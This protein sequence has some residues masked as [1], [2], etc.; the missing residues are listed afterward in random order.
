MRL[1]IDRVSVAYNGTRVVHGVSVALA[2]SEWIALIGPN[3]A[4]KS[5]LLKAIASLLPYDGGIAF[6][7]VAVASLS[8]RRGARSW[9]PTCPSDRCCPTG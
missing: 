7:D 5:T 4:G 2:P 3:G 6:D 8:R 9:R 1:T